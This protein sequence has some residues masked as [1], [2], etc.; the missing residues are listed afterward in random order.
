MTGGHVV[1]SFSPKSPAVIMLYAA[2]SLLLLLPPSLYAPTIYMIY[3][4]IVLFVNSPGASVI[5]PT[6]VTKIFVVGD[7][8]A[9]FIQ[10]AGGGMMAQEGKADL[11]QKVL[12]TGLGVQLL[13]FGFFLIIEW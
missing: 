4:R 10:S 3:G 11:G 6:R 8:L 5:K 7:V 9:F 12:L 13:F 2:P 1:R